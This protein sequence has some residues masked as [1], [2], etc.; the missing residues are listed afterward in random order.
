MKKLF[1]FLCLS[2]LIMGKAELQAAN[3][4]VTVGP[5]G[6]NS[7]A[8][9]QVTI[10]AGE[11]VTWQWESGT[12]NIHSDSSPQAW[13]EAS[14]TSGNPTFSHTFNMAGTYPYHCTI[15]GQSMS[16]SI[17]ILAAPTGTKED[18]M[19]K[20]MLN[21]YPNPAQNK[22]KLEL[23]LADAD[24]YE[25]RLTN[26]IGKT[27]KTINSSEFK[28]VKATEIDLSGMAGG[29]YFYTLWNR[30]KMVETRRLVIQK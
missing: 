14:S 7:F 26:A 21:F 29:V 4:T 9:Q 28:A 11:M 23:N 16:G 12:H 24:D 20:S 1:T 8:P 19:H 30:D 27:V 6:S 17:T 22:V 5:G 18:L 15:H 25:I 10:N 3:A 13:T 2:V